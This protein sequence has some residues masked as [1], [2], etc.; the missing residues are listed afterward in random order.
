LNDVTQ[1]NPQDTGI[2]RE[3]TLQEL[4]TIPHNDTFYMIVTAF[5]G[6]LGNI[7]VKNPIEGWEILLNLILEVLILLF[8]L[9]IMVKAILYM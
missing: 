3:F 9:M 8:S 1:F 2:S 6:G 4:L 7:I 5:S